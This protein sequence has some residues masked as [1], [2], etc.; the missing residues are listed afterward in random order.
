MLPGP[1]AAEWLAV[2]DFGR[3]GIHCDPDDAGQSLLGVKTS[4][5]EVKDFSLRRTL[6]F[7]NEAFRKQVVTV[8]SVR[9]PEEECVC[10]KRSC[11]NG[12]GQ[13]IEHR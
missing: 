12:K 5:C 10:G 13:G 3:I 4:R 6:F 1:S 2:R 9:L 8:V 11:C 7:F